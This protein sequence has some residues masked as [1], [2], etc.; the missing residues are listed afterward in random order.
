MREAGFYSYDAAAE[1]ED[2]VKRWIGREVKRFL[3][4]AHI[5]LP[6]LLRLAAAP[7]DLVPDSVQEFMND[8]G[9]EDMDVDGDD[10]APTD[11]EI[12][13]EEKAEP[14]MMAHAD[15]WDRFLAWVR[16]VQEPY[17]RDDDDYRQKRA[18]EYFNHSIACSRDLIAL[19]PTLQSWVPHIS[20]FIVP[21]QIVW[22]GDPAS[23]ACDACESYGAM[24]KKLI[25][26]N[27]CRRRVRGGTSGDGPAFTHEHKRGDKKWRQSFTR[28][29]IEQ[30]FRRCCVKEQLLHGEANQPYL[31]RTD[32]KLKEKGVKRERVQSERELLPTVREQVAAE[33]ELS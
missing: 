10:F 27:T 14:T 1:D 30:A 31:Q 6:F 9:T 21:R 2:P 33:T 19:K 26:H 25:K 24:V 8:D 15:M 23:R 29:Y 12:Q 32:W 7:L 20:C 5:H 22:L 28:G 18:V 3:V 17:E 4:E 13:A 16:N 11:E